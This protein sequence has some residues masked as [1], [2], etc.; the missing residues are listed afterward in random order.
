MTA[1]ERATKVANLLKD[2]VEIGA[3]WEGAGPEERH[4]IHVML[5]RCL[6]DLQAIKDELPIFRPRP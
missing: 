4:R 5:D 6:V 3:D 1:A 2:F